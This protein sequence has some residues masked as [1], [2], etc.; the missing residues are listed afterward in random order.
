VNELNGRR[1]E[2]RHIPI[3]KVASIRF[4][5]WRKRK[6]ESREK[7]NS[8]EIDKLFMLRTQRAPRARERQQAFS[9]SGRPGG[10]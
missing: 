6:N 5:S 3:P 2:G 8:H 1:A 10:R 9:S 7:V 4:V